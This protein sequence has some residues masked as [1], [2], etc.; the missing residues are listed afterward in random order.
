MLCLHHLWSLAPG[1]STGLVWLV[2]R[3]TSCTVR[4]QAYLIERTPRAAPL[5][6]LSRQLY[7]AHFG[8]MHLKSLLAGT[9]A[10]VTV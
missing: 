10:A 1:R 7:P 4:T 2:E 5:S 6:D 3:R 8:T 9:V